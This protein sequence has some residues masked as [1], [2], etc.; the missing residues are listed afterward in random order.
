MPNHIMKT[1]IVTGGTRGLGLS[2]A[3]EI[4]K[5][6]ASEVVLAV[7]DIERGAAVAAQIGEN[8]S[9]IALD[10]RSSASVENF[11]QDWNKPIAGLVNNAGVQIV[12]A[13]R[14]T[15]EEGYEETFAV[16]H[17]HALKLTIGLLGHL[18]GGRVLFIGSGTHNPKN[19]TATIFGF[20]GAQYESIRK[21]AEGLNS[22][23]KINQLGMDRYATS[24]FL[25]MVSTVELARRISPNKTKF[26]CLDPGMMPGTGLARTAPAHLQFV[27]KNILPVISRVMPDSSTPERSG[28]AGALLMTADNSLLNNG[29]IYS[30]DKKLSIRAWEKVFSPE[31]GRSVL[32]E[33]MEMLGLDRKILY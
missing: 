22:S 19:W 7:R 18:Q 17:L 29:G 9:V 6:N 2:I 12:D 20:R 31:I 11:L 8:V 3:K 4:A 16:N 30:Y 5:S 14:Q 26:Y 13:T 24:K 1:Y 23:P 21:C 25:N 10:M 27:W 32:D 33:S 15:A 28:Q